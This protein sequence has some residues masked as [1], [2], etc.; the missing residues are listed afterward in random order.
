ML[1]RTARPLLAL[2]VGVTLALTAGTAAGAAGTSGTAAAAR[3]ADG[4][5]V[6]TDQGLV[7]GTVTDTVRTFQGI[8]YAAPPTGER[9]WA[10]PAPAPRRAG[11]LDA[12]RPGPA[13]PQTGVIAPLGTFSDNEDCL[14]LNVTTPRTSPA[15]PRP[16]MV[17]LHG[18][19]HNDGAGAMHGA[20]R[21]AAQGDV[22]AVTVNYRLGALGYLAHPD[23]EKRGES[24]NYG[25][26]DQQEAL[27]WVRRNAAAFGGDPHNVTLFG[28]SAGGHS[29]CAHMVAP[30]S[31]GLFDRVILQ[32]APCTGDEGGRDRAA[33]LAD[34]ERT[35]A[36]ITD[37]L[38]QAGAPADWRTADTEYLVRAPFGQEP[39]YAPSYGGTLLPRTPREAF[40]SGR[41]NRVPV[42][43]GTNRDE[44][45]GRVYAMEGQKKATT[46]DPDARLDQADVLAFLEPEFGAERARAIAARYPADAYDGS[47]ALALA[48]ALTDGNWSRYTVDMGRALSA[49]TRT[50][51]YE[52]AENDVPWY[53]GPSIPKP[54]GPTGAPH[55]FELPYIFELAAHEQLT[56][57][58]RALSDDMIRI[59]TDFAR[60]GTPGSTADW[61]P[62][63][64]AAVN[65]LSLASGPNGI[66]PVHF[67]KDHRYGF[68]KSLD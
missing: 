37:R 39:A 60:T 41:F 45:R 16:V 26:L 28:E 22:I 21:L 47:Y 13:C 59:W 36:G 51:T 24:G 54:A 42:L 56:P 55:T 63:T 11:I 38:K 33:A 15:R 50:Y 27:R 52:F 23:L 44:E 46:G 57:A 8:P 65:A 35:A 6:R 48:A 49:R 66:R 7:R 12:T 53:A 32:S 20:G 62:T 3:H 64:P 30:S 18:G 1:K 5:T 58:Q 34:G 10:P 17:Y 25:F 61:K 40:A 29:S 68:W 19:D 4:P 43:L 14:F 67:A 31:A 2:A 9:R